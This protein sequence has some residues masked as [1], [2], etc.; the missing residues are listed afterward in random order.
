[1]HTKLLGM[2]EQSGK[3]LLAALMSSKPCAEDRG[4]EK[5]C[6]ES[7]A[8]RFLLC[9][10]EF[11]ILVSLTH[12]LP[13]TEPWVPATRTQRLKC[14]TSR[15]LPHSFISLSTLLFIFFLSL[16]F[17]IVAREGKE[18]KHFR[19]ERLVCCIIKMSFVITFL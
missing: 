6:Q 16:P 4:V 17:L 3:W 11:N 9:H 18:K 12:L 5:L 10:C 8:L 15:P 19:N 7:V 14:S 13:T 2:A 1:M